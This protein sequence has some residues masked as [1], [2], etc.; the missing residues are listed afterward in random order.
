MLLA[1][2]ACHVVKLVKRVGD[3]WIDVHS[4]AGDCD[5]IRDIY[6]CGSVWGRVPRE[7]QLG[8]SIRVRVELQVDGTLRNIW[9]GR[10]REGE[11]GREEGRKKKE[12]RI[13]K[14]EKRGRENVHKMNYCH[15]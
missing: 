2:L 7:R 14:N 13:E 11:R 4:R 15:S 3:C 9:R 12:K 10:G 8:E 5:H 6:S 1:C